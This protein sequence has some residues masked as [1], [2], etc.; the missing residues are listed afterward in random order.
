MAV[1]SPRAGV[2]RL[3]CP[4]PLSET[5]ALHGAESDRPRSIRSDRGRGSYAIHDDARPQLAEMRCCWRWCWH[6]GAA[7]LFDITFSSSCSR[8]ASCCSTSV[9]VRW[10]MMRLCCLFARRGDSVIVSLPGRRCL[11]IP[12]PLCR[13]GGGAAGAALLFPE[14]I[15][16]TRRD[17]AAD[18]GRFTFWSGMLDDGGCGVLRPATARGRR[19]SDDY[20]AFPHHR[21]RLRWLFSVALNST[22]SWRGSRLGP[23]F[24][25]AALVP[26]DP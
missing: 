13:L 18:A 25:A 4:G 6:A 8:H 22:P 7:L 1:R 10:P 11:R 12:G 17:V 9:M 20:R 15:S 21:A 23:S 2:F 24:V 19:P 16:R 5:E 14:R 3:R 26:A